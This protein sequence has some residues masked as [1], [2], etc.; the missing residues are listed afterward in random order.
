MYTNSNAWAEIKTFYHLL[1]FLIVTGALTLEDSSEC[2]DHQKEENV[3][4]QDNKDKY[5]MEVKTGEF[6]E[7]EVLK[8]ELKEVLYIYW[9]LRYF[10]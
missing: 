4:G 5:K 6:D 3:D 1:N 9:Y 10:N 2:S 7:K 8:K